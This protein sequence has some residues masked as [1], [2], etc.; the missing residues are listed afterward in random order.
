MS[1]ISLDVYSGVISMI[2]TSVVPATIN[3]KTYN[4]DTN[5][6]VFTNLIITWIYKN[7]AGVPL[8][9]DP[10]TD[11]MTLGSIVKDIGT[12]KKA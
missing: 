5:T 8:G 10:A 2:Y 6:S 3:C 12:Y 4:D 1:N 7:N 9:A 11:P